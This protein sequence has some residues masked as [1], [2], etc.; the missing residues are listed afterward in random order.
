MVLAAVREDRSSLGEAVIDWISEAEAEKL[1]KEREKEIGSA[2][3]VL[4]E[5]PP[6]WHWECEKESV[7]VYAH[8]LDH[9]RSETDWND[10]MY[11]REDPYVG[12]ALVRCPKC[13]ATARGHF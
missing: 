7:A 5:L 8:H 3:L 13:G 9:G 11:Q 12:H 10:V 2:V 4:P 6:D 1:R